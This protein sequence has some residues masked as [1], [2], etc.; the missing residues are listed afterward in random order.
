VLSFIDKDTLEY[1]VIH[2]DNVRHFR[3]ITGVLNYF[4]HV[5]D[6]RMTKKQYLNE[7]STIKTEYNPLKPNGFDADGTYDECISTPTLEV[8]RDLEAYKPN[9]KHP[10]K[11][12][13]FFNA[14]IPDDKERANLLKFLACKLSKFEHDNTIINIYYMLAG[15]D[16][17]IC[18]SI[19]RD[20]LSNITSTS[21]TQTRMFAHFIYDFKY[22][23]LMDNASFNWL[24]NY[25]CPIK[26]RIWN[27]LVGISNNELLPITYKYMKP[28]LIHNIMTNVIET[29]QNLFTIK[30][31]M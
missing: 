28:K 3:Y 18:N 6:I 31:V 8:I 15:G 9:Y 5:S 27:K 20:I 1:K 26:A 14:Y 13:Q 24:Y 2:C 12:M 21:F 7:L 22:N 10:K 23:N 25:D 30:R 29:E 19:F 11:T 16:N 4:N 17:Y